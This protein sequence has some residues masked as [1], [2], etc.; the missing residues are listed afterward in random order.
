MSPARVLTVL[1]L[2]FM[3]GV[4]IQAALGFS[5]WLLG[6]LTISLLVAGLT[7]LTIPA[8]KITFGFFVI[9]GL[10]TGFTRASTFSESFSPASERVFWEKARSELVSRVNAVLPNPESAVF[11]AM[12]FG[13][14][15]DIPSNLKED[16]N[17][18][19]TRHILAISGMNITI[20]A[21]LLLSLGI[22]LGLWR[23][24]AFWVALAGI[25]AF[26][27]LVGSPAS[28]ARAG[29]MGSLML[30]AKNRGRLVQAWRPV[31]LAALFMVA[32][33]PTLLAFDIGF[34]LSFLAV[35]GL[36]FFNNFWL[37]VFSFIPFKMIR[38]LVALSMSAQLATWPVIMF[39]FGTFSTISIIA[40]VFVVPL[41]TPIMFLGLGFTAVSW[42]PLLSQ[43]FLWPAWLILRITTRLVS[44]FSLWPGASLNPG[45][46]GWLALAVYYPLLIWF[47]RFLESK[48][49]NESGY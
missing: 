35:M 4:A 25:A 28:A 18:T 13:Y 17:R 36:I 12:V 34:Q 32:A 40:N 16:F 20:V 43:V 9:L 22:Y 10:L 19:G 1:A 33:K 24:Q 15:K 2:S 11:N 48:G 45:R 37:R 46:L 5:W 6:F 31:T 8:S 47:W 26:I 3:V 42:W 38:E 29:L 7:G 44:F 21:S 49:L 27:F 30:W 23:R 39:N 14:E 41:L